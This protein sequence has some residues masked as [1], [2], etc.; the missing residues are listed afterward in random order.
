MNKTKRTSVL[1]I[2]TEIAAIVLFLL[3]FKGQKMQLWI[4]IFGISALLS[5]F[6]GRFYCSWI[7]PSNTIFRGIR[8]VFKK[9]KINRVRTPKFLQ[10]N[11]IRLIF[12][13]LFIFS[14]IAMKVLNLKLSL[15]LYITIL[16][17]FFS[18]IFEEKFW[19]RHLCPFGTILSFTSRKAAYK[20]K[21]NEEDCIS[22]GKC[23]KVCPTSSIVTLENKKR[24]NTPH[25]CLLCRRCIPVCPTEVC[26]FIRK[27]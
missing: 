19:H 23:Q 20:L 14:M 10:N 4:V 2:I 3:L 12:L 16:S 26:R 7:C 25:E 1:R 11:T 8:W 5:I 24:R 21:I 17:I 6:F 13:I 18:L 15:I 9:L 22:C 27:S